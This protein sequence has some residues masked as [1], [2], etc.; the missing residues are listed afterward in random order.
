MRT[1]FHDFDDPLFSFHRR[2]DGLDPGYL[3]FHTYY[4]FSIVTSGKINIIEEGA[5]IRC[6]EPCIIVHA[7]YSFHEIIAERG[8][9][10]D[11][12]VF[13]F[14]KECA[15]ELPSCIN[16]G[17]L[18]ARSLTVIPINEEMGAKVYPLIAAYDACKKDEDALKILIMTCLLRVIQENLR[19]AITDSACGFPD[20]LSY[21]RDVT[22]YINSHYSDRLS[23]DDIAKVWFISRQKL[24][25][26]FKSVMS[27]TLKQYILDARIAN[28]IRLLSMGGKVS[29]VTYECGFSCESHFIH[30]FKDRIGTSPY[31]FSKN[32][33]FSVN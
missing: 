3:H 21:I 11:H 25:A 32:C 19:F 4:E 20:R 30:I 22:E 7:P 26:D 9:P 2:T 28:A 24:D 14:S 15:S 13:H 1:I 27:V 6:E 12:V 29:D 23:A 17:L 18:Y 5:N 8:T 16:I 10:Y 33:S 31:K